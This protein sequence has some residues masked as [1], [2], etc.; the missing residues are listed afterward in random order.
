VSAALG[1]SIAVGGCAGGPDAAGDASASSG[2]GAGADATDEPSEAVDEDAAVVPRRLVGTWRL[3]SLQGEAIDPPASMDAETPSVALAADGSVTGTT[4]VNR[5]TGRVEAAG[6]GSDALGFA[7][8]A[9]T[10]RAGPPAAM[11]LERRFLQV[12]EMTDRMRREGAAL[13]L[14]R[15]DR[16]L[17]RLLPGG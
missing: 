3:E 4:G 9:T 1:A 14:A 6:L 7:P 17:A 10:R 13:V 16:E 8:L 12:L 11:E 2:A 5:L 15:G